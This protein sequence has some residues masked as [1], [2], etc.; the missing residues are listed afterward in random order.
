MFFF[1]FKKIVYIQDI[2]IHLSLS[3]IDATFS[4]RAANSIL[5][6]FFLW[7]FNCICLFFLYCLELD[8]NLIVSVPVFTN[9]VSSGLRTFDIYTL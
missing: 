2:R 6:L 3:N 5:H 7:L 8:M 9:F 4:E 1:S